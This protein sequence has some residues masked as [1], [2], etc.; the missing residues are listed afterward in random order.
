[1]G[2]TLDDGVDLG[3]VTGALSKAGINAL[4]SSGNMRNVGDIME[5]LMGVWGQMDQTQK[6]AIATTLA[7]KYQLARF[8]ALMNRSDLYETYKQS[9]QTGKDKGTLDVMNEKYI[10]SLEGKL[11]QLQATAEGFLNTFLQGDSLYGFIDGLSNVVELLNDMTDS[12]G[13]GQQALSL[14]GATATRVFSSQIGTQLGNMAQNFSVNAQKKRNAKTV[15][16]QLDVLGL[17]DIDDKKIKDLSDSMLQGLNLSAGANDEQRNQINE[18]IEKQIQAKQAQLDAETELTNTVSALN[19]AYKNA[20]QGKQIEAQTELNGDDSETAFKQYVDTDYVREVEAKNGLISAKEADATVERIKEASLETTKFSSAVANLR[21]EVDL[22]FASEEKDLKKA[23]SALTDAF[24]SLYEIESIVNLT[25]EQS[26]KLADIFERILNISSSSSLSDFDKIAVELEQVNNELHDTFSMVQNLA[27]NE[28]AT[29]KAIVGGAA[30]LESVLNKQGIANTANDYQKEQS[31]NLFKGIDFGQ[32]LANVANF[33]G[34]IGQLAFA[35]SSFQNL[36]SIWA[37]ADLSDGEKIEQTILN[38]TMTLPSAI[39]ALSEMRTI[40][41]DNSFGKLA[42]SLSAASLAQK[43]LAASTMAETAAAKT[44]SVT[45][46]ATA[47]KYTALG[48]GATVAATGV[49]ALGTAMKALAG[50]AGWAL[51]AVTALFDVIGIVSNYNNQQLEDQLNSANEAAQ[52]ASD[53][54]DSLKTSVASFEE[55]YG[56]YKNGES[57]SNELKSEADA[58]NETLGDQTLKVLAA[59]GAWDQYAQK[60]QEVSAQKTEDTL[61]TLESSQKTLDSNAKGEGSNTAKGIARTTGKPWHASIANLLGEKTG[62]T[63]NSQGKYSLSSKAGIQQ[64]INDIETVGNF[65]K[66]QIK[67]VEE[68]LKN[69]DETSTQH[70]SLNKKLEQLNAEYN[71]L[72]TLESDNSEKFEQFE[73]NQQAIANTNVSLNKDKAEYQYRSGQSLEDYRSSLRSTDMYQSWASDYGYEAAE[74]MLQYFIE[75]M[76]SA[77]EDQGLNNAILADDARMGIA[78]RAYQLNGNSDEAA[79]NIYN[80]ISSIS[81]EDIIKLKASIDTD[82]LINNVDDIVNKINNGDDLNDIILGINVK[83]DALLKDYS[84]VSYDSVFDDAGYYNTDET[85]AKLEDLDVSSE[86]FKIYVENLQSSSSALQEWNN[87]L[88]GTEDYLNRQQTILATDITRQRSYLSTLDEGSEAY[89]TQKEKVEEVE[90]AYIDNIKA[91]QKNKQAQENY[92]HTLNDIALDAE[93]TAQGLQEL[94]DASDEVY[95]VLQDSLSNPDLISTTQYADAIKTMQ[96]SLGKALNIDGT[97]LDGEWI[98]NNLDLIKAAADGDIEAIQELRFQAAQQILLNVGLEPTSAPGIASDLM[99]LF[100]YAQSIL[101]NI[102][103]GAN[104]DDSYFTDVLNHMLENTSLTAEQIDGILAA[105]SGMGLDTEIQYVEKSMQVPKYNITGYQDDIESANSGI[106]Q[107]S[108]SYETQTVKVPQLVSVKKKDISG[109]YA[110]ATAAGYGGSSGSSGSGSGGSGGSGSSYEAK[111]KDLIEDEPDRYEKVNTQLEKIGN[112]LDRIADEQD[113]LTGDKLV[114]NMEKQISLLQRQKQIQQ[115]KLQIQQQEAQE[116]QDKLSSQYGVQFDSEGY[117]SNYYA[118]HQGL[119][120]RV[121]NLTN[122][123]NATSDEAGQESLEEQIENAQDALDKFNT[124]Y[125]RYDELWSG[126]LEN[127][128]TAL[129][130][131]EDKIEDIRISAFKTGVEAADNIKDI[132]EALIKFNSLFEDIYQED[133]FVLA[134]DSI[135]KLSKYFDV[136]TGNMEEYYDTMIAKMKEAA[137]QEGV[138]DSYKTYAAQQIAKMEEAK[139]QSG[140]GT[141]ETYGTGYLDMTLKN[142]EDIMS[143]IKQ[144]K[145]TGKSDIFGEDSADM[146]NVAKDIFDKATEMAQDFASQ[147]KELRDQIIDCIDEIGDEAERRQK[148]FQAITDQLEHQLNI[149]EM[150]RGEE[151][152]DEVNQVLMAQQSAYKAQINEAQTVLN[153]YNELLKILPEG[154]EEWENVQ[155][156]IID[157]QSELNSLVETSLENMLKVYTNTVNKITKA[158]VSNALGTDINWMET[159]WELI[160]RNADYYLDD[161]NKAYNIQKLQGKY[162]DLLDG[163]NDLATQ[164]KISEQMQEQLTYLREKTKLSEY[165]V[166][167]ANAQLEILQKQIALEDA[168]RN[169]NQMKLRRDSQG[170]YSYVYTADQDSVRD[171]ESDLLDVQNNAYNLSKEQ[172]KQTQ[173]DSISALKDAQSTINDIWTNANLTLEEK[174]ARTQTIIDSLKEYLAATSEQLGTSQT[175]IIND[176]IGMCETLV[177]ENKSGMTDIYDQ[178]INGNKDAF[179]QIDTRWQTSLTA[180]LQNLDTFN[181]QTDNA[182]NDLIANG[183]E[184]QKNVSEISGLV[185]TDFNNTTDVID[186]CK[187]ATNDLVNSSK[188]FFNLINDQSGTIVEYEDKLGKMSDKILDMTN[189]MT[190]Y[191][192]QVNDLANQLTAKEQENSQLYARIDQL[193]HPE[194][195][196]NGS[197]SG[198]GGG[199]GSGGADEDTA[200]RIANA[201]WGMGDKGG[202]YDDPSRSTLISERYGYAMYEAVQALFNS[203]YGYNWIDYS[204]GYEHY[205]TGGYTGSW[206]NT[207]NGRFAMLHQKELVLNESDTENILEAVKQIRA[208]SNS[209]I[210]NI[211][212]NAAQG[213]TA[214]AGL[215]STNRALG[216]EIDQNVHITAEFPSATDANE[217]RSALE[218]LNN[219][220]AQYAFRTK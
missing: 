84:S 126:D 152:Y 38:L 1:M 220:A 10:D 64:Q 86:Q 210:S 159:Q 182:F 68:E 217:I 97:V 6:A 61:D 27:A 194:K 108:V 134:A 184:W 196:N 35:W 43:E 177:D 66:E 76:Q 208:L 216:G 113:R 162:L 114:K 157:A 54:I 34:A 112:E 129:E 70:K 145:E 124:A 218:S 151:A 170:N 17:G 211:L 193:E 130:D 22:A 11:N 15:Q 158:W 99:D 118:I 115:E 30:G 119:I 173:D 136:A 146:Y 128:L 140:Q 19:I 117:M 203:G 116:L 45:A 150:L 29:K 16:S 169:K 190:A 102:E 51:L 65:Y 212:S 41:K 14:F 206:D 179:D 209:G 55:L 161:V 142:L 189:K 98:T 120:D 199:S 105:L 46:S 149:V 90:Q 71:S 20:L 107:G 89:A 3:Q 165:D 205:D 185:N 12:I 137:A 58:L 122:Q 75:G 5:D 72:K 143:E 171:A 139:K 79:D 103:V 204:K 133:P 78:Q 47:I 213:L 36:G 8:E 188:D 60:L 164:K 178:I 91:I 175:N 40:M 49:R 59:T 25:A 9:S 31:E 26:D 87:S 50:P 101:P 93:E 215:L 96:D 181:S 123:Y 67:S 207:S 80:K 37:N 109:S 95:G 63:L 155:D 195:Y 104:I 7:G 201:I 214:Y 166:N 192:E 127:T 111:T 141:L 131:L 144:F 135:E 106:V 28:G 33:T 48:A 219:Y 73:S 92:D 42:D 32:Q 94:A 172:M 56:K 13:G 62:I 198:S 148:S 154:S 163:S 81:D 100:A 24:N 186:K 4:D 2:E 21:D 168:Q 180:W 85:T 82:M 83:S 197:S 138:S 174:K 153:K 53:S 125:K 183:E 18:V 132:Q 156:K 77:V 69:T 187:D 39:T 44:S 57:T 74:S 52:E 176:F 167:Y 121:N 191:K 202:W 147:M 23:N 110:A 88:Q 160:N 200:Y